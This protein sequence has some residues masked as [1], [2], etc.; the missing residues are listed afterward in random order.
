MKSDPKPDCW[1][2]GLLPKRL[3]VVAK[4]EELSGYPVNAACACHLLGS[5]FTIVGTVCS[6]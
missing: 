4:W 3:L 6:V 2:D 5:A 1:E